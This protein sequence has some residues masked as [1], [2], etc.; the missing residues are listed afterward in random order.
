MISERIFEQKGED[1]F[2]CGILHDIG[3]IVEDQVAHELFIKACKAYQPETKVITEYEK[4]IIGADHSSIGLTLAHEW[5]FPLE[6]Q[7]GIETHHKSL[8]EVTPSSITGIIQIA[9]HFVCKLDYPA[10]PGMNGTLSPPLVDHVRNNL[11]E[12][13]ALITDFPEEMSKAKELYET[14]EA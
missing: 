3:M 11:D 7:E 14:H 13:K 5:N 12:Y 4:E 2:L 1:A 9:E 8:Q 10:L 6:V